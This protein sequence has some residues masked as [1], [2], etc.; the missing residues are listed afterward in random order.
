MSEQQDTSCAVNRCLCHDLSFE[1][2]RGLAEEKGLDFEGL[3]TE[4]DCSMGCGLCEPYVRLML[5]T[6]KTEFPVLSAEEIEQVMG[7]DGGTRG[8]LT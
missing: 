2:L 7:E 4:T 8:G 5:K 1:D 6:G 3:Q